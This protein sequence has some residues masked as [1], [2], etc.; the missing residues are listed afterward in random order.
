MTEFK[1]TSAFPIRDARLAHYSGKNEIREY[2]EEMLDRIL[3]VA[4]RKTRGEL[5][6]MFEEE[7][8]KADDQGVEDGVRDTEQRY[9]KEFAKT[10]Q[11][12]R[13]I[14]DTFH[15][16]VSGLIE[17][18]EQEILKLVISIA[19]KVVETEISLQPE[20]VLNVL[21]NAL[22]LL[23]DR[24]SIRIHVHPDDWTTV[25]NSLDGLDVK[26]ELPRD[27]DVISDPK[28]SPGGCLVDSVSGSI[29]ADLETQ[30][31]EIRRKLLKDE[32]ALS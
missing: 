22:N 17:N 20:I 27:V 10:F 32:S 28:V 14:T 18:E 16:E 11:L 24:R 3:S 8:K 4:D 15:H 31:A 13:K 12:L 6:T 5:T 26:V 25:K 7:R 29:D 19:R 23:N 9:L 1:F 21:R 30:F 2:S